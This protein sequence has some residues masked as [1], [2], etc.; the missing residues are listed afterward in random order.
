MFQLLERHITSTRFRAHK[1]TEEPCTFVPSVPKTKTI[2]E[3]QRTQVCQKKKGATVAQHHS[4]YII[5]HI[6]Q[7]TSINVH[8][9]RKRRTQ[10][11]KS[12]FTQILFAD[13]GRQRQKSFPTVGQ[14]NGTNPNADRPKQIHKHNH[15][16]K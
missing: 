7:S 12:H 5:N 13:T 6:N 10:Y 3:H 9:Q 2:W 11:G 8:H 14:A 1:A 4:K 16:G 15:L